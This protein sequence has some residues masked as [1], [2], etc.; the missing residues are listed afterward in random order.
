MPDDL[1]A[2]VTGDIVSRL[3]DWASLWADLLL[4]DMALHY[5]DSLPDVP[6]NLF[7]RR[8]LWE[9]AVVA[10][11]RTIK[12]GRRQALIRDLLDDL[13]PGA[14]ECHDD[15]IAWRDRHIAHRVDASRETVTTHAVIDPDGPRVVGVHIRVS[16][17]TEPDQEGGQL[18]ATFQ[19]HIKVL[20]D[21]AWE[22]RLQ[23]LE[24]EVVEHY[25]SKLDSLIA[26]ASPPESSTAF[27][28]NIRPS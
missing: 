8:A 16:P 6:T 26:T 20:R 24:T 1:E 17:A 18:V 19:G 2:L 7:A 28:V 9:G 14:K 4:V 21:L 5:R 15:V 27:S 22:Q 13:G 3:Q 23:P 11:G 10:Y 12:I 25:M